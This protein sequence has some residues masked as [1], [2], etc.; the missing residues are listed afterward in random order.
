[1]LIIVTGVQCRHHVRFI[2]TRGNKEDLLSLHNIFHAHGHCVRWHL[3]HGIKKTTI[4]DTCLH[5]QINHMG[6]AIKGRARLIKADMTIVAKSE[7]L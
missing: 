7:K 1:M 4:I 5:G 2:R 3:I 6:A